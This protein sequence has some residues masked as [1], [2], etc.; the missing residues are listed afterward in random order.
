MTPTSYS[1]TQQTVNRFLGLT[2]GGAAVLAVGALFDQ[3]RAWAS[4][5]LACFYLLSLGLGGLVLVAFSYVTG[6]GW[7]VA[8][9]R[10]PEAMAGIIPWA[11]IGMLAVVACQVQGPGGYAWH[12]H[13]EGDPGT[14][15]FKELW[16]DPSFFIGRAI[17]YLVLWFLFARLIVGVSR[18]Q[19]VRGGSALTRLAT[20]LSAAFLLV[21]AFTYSSASVDWILGLEPMWFSTMWGVYSFCG[22]VSSSLAAVVILALLLRRHGPLKGIFTTDHLH[23][24]GKLLLGFSCFWMYIWFSQYMLIWY[25]NIPEETS[26]FILRTR[27]AWWPLVVA[28]VVLNWVVPLFALLPR[29][30]KRSARIMAAVAAVVLIGRWLDLYIMILPSTIGETPLVGIPEIAAATAL[31]GA[32]GLVFLRSFAKAN[33]VPVQ[34]PF[35]VE[36]LHHHC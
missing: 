6:A 29:P 9:R 23:D 24:L 21:F 17:G 18:R 22:L 12:P 33:T 27:S 3:Q 31:F 5:L 4:L 32:F 26:Y 8:F 19:D 2:I 28:N 13:G 34:D 30:A 14:F 11:G 20:G 1:P 7:S 15:W 35:L 36:S 25:T 10:I 16:L